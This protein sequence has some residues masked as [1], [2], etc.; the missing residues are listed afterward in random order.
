M[1]NSEKIKTFLD[2]V[3]ECRSLNEIARN[4][5]SE[6]EKLQQD[7]LHAIEFESNGKKRSVIDTKLHKCR[8]SRRKYKDIFEE[9]DDIVQSFKDPSHKKT[10]EQLRQLLGKVRKMERYHE[11]RTYIPRAKE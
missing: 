2:F 8:L 7:L 5:I 11:N 9:T 10:L 1:R 3:D 4:G 6:E